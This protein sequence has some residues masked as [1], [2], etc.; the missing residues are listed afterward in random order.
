MVN[1]E[2]EQAHP[3]AAIHLLIT[4]TGNGVAKPVF[5]LLKNNAH[6]TNGPGRS[7]LF[8]RSSNIAAGLHQVF[9]AGP[10]QDFFFFFAQRLVTFLVDLV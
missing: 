3:S 8:Y 1:F 6:K 2:N 4:A 7:H 5:C 10:F 9:L